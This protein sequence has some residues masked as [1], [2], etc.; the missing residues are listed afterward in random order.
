MDRILK[1]FLGKLKN[2]RIV[3]ID[4]EEKLRLYAIYFAITMS[5]QG[6]CTQEYQKYS[7][8]DSLGENDTGLQF[9]EGYALSPQLSGL[10][11]PKSKSRM[12]LR[13]GFPTQQLS[14]WFLKV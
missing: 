5:V 14:A 8:S 6:N 1:L 12:Y 2:H 9:K 4:Q 3:S 13:H 11:T 7:Y 10:F